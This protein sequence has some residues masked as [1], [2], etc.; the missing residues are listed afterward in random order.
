M[1]ELAERIPVSRA[2][3]RH[4]I[5]SRTLKKWLRQDLGYDFSEGARLALLADVDAV[6][7]K[8]TAKS[9]AARRRVRRLADAVVSRK[10]AADPQEMAAAG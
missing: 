8:H 7:I 3:R 5:D 10:P 2:A 6:I 4:G 1:K 9:G